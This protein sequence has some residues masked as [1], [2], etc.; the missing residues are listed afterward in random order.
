[1]GIRILNLTEMSGG[2][3]HLTLRFCLLE[4]P[5]FISCILSSTVFFTG[6]WPR[7]YPLQFCGV[8]PWAVDYLWGWTKSRTAGGAEGW[9]CV[10]HLLL[11]DGHSGMDWESPLCA[12]LQPGVG[13]GKRPMKMRGMRQPYWFS[14]QGTWSLW[15]PVLI[16][17][18]FLFLLVL[19]KKKNLF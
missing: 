1:M 13:A 18:L 14:S 3:L 16:A 12:A 6:I 5:C 15:V 10:W 19:L 7:C 4:H 17:T 11:G 9:L 8:D 2:F